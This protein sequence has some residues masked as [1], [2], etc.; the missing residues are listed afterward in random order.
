MPAPDLHTEPLGGADPLDRRRIAALLADTRERTLSLVERLDERDVNRVHSTLMSPLAWDIGHIA[1]FEDLWLA[2]RAGGLE[3][4]RPELWEVYDAAETPR[5]DRGELPY[6]RSGEAREY[7]AAVRERSLAVLDRV[8]LEGDGDR[9]NHAGFVWDMVVRHEMQHNETMAQTICLA[10]PGMYE[11]IRR[12]LPA[13]PARAEQRRVRIDGG[14]IAVGA[15][16]SGFAYDNERPAFEVELAPFEIDRL[17]VSNGDWLQF[18]ADGGYERRVLWSDAGWA[19]RVAEA[20]ERPLHWSADGGERYCDLIEPIDPNLPVMHVSWFEA[21]AF[22]RWAGRRLPTE[23]EWE[24]AAGPGR[25]WPW[26]DEAPGFARTNL[27][28]TGWGPAPVGA[29]PA[30]ASANGVLGM[31]GDAWEWTSSA[32]TAYPG[33]EAFPYDEYSAPFFGGEYRVL[34]GGSWATRGRAVTNAFR[35]WDLPGRRQ[36]FSGVRLANDA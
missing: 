26:G 15:R 10:A 14:R 29:Y 19:W 3:P 2:S 28:L 36:I 17:P 20:A 18:L 33:F 32:F 34:R 12:P 30:G 11:P 8:D 6:L 1:A 22:A 21:C 4:L 16:T 9:L 35:N 31:V 7:M 5:C 27:G 13:R 25:T 24:R 23:H